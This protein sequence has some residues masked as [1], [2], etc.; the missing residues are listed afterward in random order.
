MTRRIAILGATG[1]VAQGLAEHLSVQHELRL[2][3]R[4]AHAPLAM[5]PYDGEFDAVI[6]CIGQGKA[7]DHEYLR[8]AE[9]YDNMVLDWLER[10]P[11]AVY[12]HLSSGAVHL[13]YPSVYA[14]SKKYA[15]AKHRASPKKK[16]VDLRLYSY[17]GRHMRGD[18]EGFVPEVLRAVREGRELITS[19]FDFRRDYVH[20]ADLASLVRC[21]MACP[22]NYPVE[23][24][25][26]KPVTKYEIL[27][28]FSSA[29]GLR[30]F[31]N[32]K[33]MEL[34]PTGFKHNYVPVDKAA[35]GIG[36]APVHSSMDAIR[37]AAEWL[38]P[39]KA[40]A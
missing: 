4:H 37:D 13:H 3:A 6:N 26:L 33:F 34:S 16:I 1:H 5:F 10:H 25:S 7:P 36:Y 11:S 12:I 30:A 17:I 35:L 39:A 15:E 20:P 31:Q 32:Q 2:Y 24:Y 9:K 19:I 8:T 21:I 22:G 40:V 18:T 29:W 27:K 14:M 23:A 28:Y 38:L